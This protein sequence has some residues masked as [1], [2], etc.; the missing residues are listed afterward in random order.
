MTKF[1]KLQNVQM[2][3][4]WDKVYLHTKSMGTYFINPNLKCLLYQTEHHYHS[5]FGTQFHGSS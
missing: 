3:R 1:L 2:F 5:H 4:T